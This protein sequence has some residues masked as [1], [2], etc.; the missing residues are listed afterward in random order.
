MELTRQAKFITDFY[1][2]SP[3]V[4]YQG[5]LER[6]IEDKIDKELLTFAQQEKKK[7]A[8]VEDKVAAILSIFHRDEEGRPILGSWM[9]RKCLMNTAYAIFNAQKDKTHPKKDQIPMAIQLVEP[10]H[11]NIFK[12]SNNQ[13]EPNRMIRDSIP[14]LDALRVPDGVATYTVSIS[15]PKPRSFFKAYEYIKAGAQFRFTVLF[16][17]DLLS[18]EKMEYLLSKAGQ[19][20]V[21][22][23]RERFGKFVIVERV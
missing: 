22:A 12:S 3:A 4:G 16:D 20:G 6:Y 15:K 23:F 13:T 9:L 17:E 10:V 8:T 2:S 7:G 14:Q 11:I 5:V 18:L 21:G 1:G 19:I